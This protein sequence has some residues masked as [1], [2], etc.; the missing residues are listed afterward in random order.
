MGKGKGI[1]FTNHNVSQ[2]K[3]GS[4]NPCSNEFPSTPS[5]LPG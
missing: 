1:Y 3:R 4:T 5:V 2:N